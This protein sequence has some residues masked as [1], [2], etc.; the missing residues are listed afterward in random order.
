MFG[1]RLAIVLALCAASGCA[2][3]FDVDPAAITAT[4]QQTQDGGILVVTGGMGAVSQAMAAS[5]RSLGVDIR[6]DAAVAAVCVN[7]GAVCAV[8]TEDGVHIQR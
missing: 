8:V 7:D 1:S 6:V 3:G 4:I 2:Q 5:A